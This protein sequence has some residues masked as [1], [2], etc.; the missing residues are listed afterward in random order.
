MN[1]GN[2]AL[3]PIVSC[4]LKNG[5]R[6]RPIYVL[7]DSGCSSAAILSV[8]AKSVEVVPVSHR[9]KLATFDSDQTVVRDF[10][11]FEVMSLDRTVC[12]S[13][14]EALVGDSLTVS[15]DRPPTNEE[16]TPFDY[17]RG[18]VF[19]ELA[20]TTIGIIL[21]APYAHLWMDGETR[22]HSLKYPLA[23]RTKLGW[24]LI[25]PTLDAK[26]GGKDVSVAAC[27]PEMLNLHLEVK[28]M[29]RHEYIMPGPFVHPE[30]VFPSRQD[31][32][33]Q[34]QMEKSIKFDL[35]SGRYSVALPWRNGRKEAA[36]R[37][38]LANSYATARRRLL[39]EKPK[40]ERDEFRRDGVFA[41]LE[42][43]IN[44]GHVRRVVE[45]DLT[46]KP[47]WYS[48]VVIVE[49]PSKPVE[50]RFRMCQDC[51][52]VSQS[53]E[54]GIWLNAELSTGPDV[55]TRLTSILFKF[56][57]HPY[58]LMADVSDFFH[59]I[60][61]NDEDVAALRFLFFKDKSMREIE[62]FELLVHLFGGGSSPAVA[63][64]T[65]QYHAGRIRAKYGEFIYWEIMMKFYVDDYL[66]SVESVQKA[67]DT[68]QQMTAAL[69]E[70][71]F[72]LCKWASNDDR[73]LA[74][75]VV[76]SSQVPLELG[77]VASEGP[78]SAPTVAQ[79][80]VDPEI[81]PLHSPLSPAPETE[82]GEDIV[83]LEND[84]P[85]LSPQ[86]KARQ[87][88]E[89]FNEEMKGFVRPDLDASTKV[90]GVGYDKKKDLLFVR[91]PAQAEKEVFTMTDVL[92]IVSAYFDPLGISAPYVLEGKLIFQE[93]V[94][95]KLTWKEP[96]PQD[97]K[98]RFMK[99][100]ATRDGLRQVSV[101]RWTS[102]WELGESLVDLC[103]YADASNEGYGASAY[104]RRY[105]PGEETVRTWLIFGKGHVV[106]T[107]MH[108]DKFEGQID[109]NGSIPRVELT[110]AR[111]AAEICSMV[112]RE[113]GETFNN[114]YLFADSMSVILWLRD[115][116]R[117]HKTF[118]F[119]R[120]RRIWNLTEVPWWRYCPTDSNP[121][122]IL[123]HPLS[124][125][126]RDAEK[127]RLYLEGPEWLRLPTSQWPTEPDIPADKLVDIAV[128]NALV[129]FDTTT[130]F[131]PRQSPP[132][133]AP[134]SVS[135]GV[136]SAPAL[137]VTP[138]DSPSNSSSASS[139]AS[140]SSS[141]HASSLPGRS[142][143]LAPVDHRTIVPPVRDL[144]LELTEKRSK[145]A[146][147]VN[148]IA[149]LTQYLQQ[150]KN[151]V[152]RRPV[153]PIVRTFALPSEFTVAEKTLLAA[154]QRKYFTAE[155]QLLL[156]NAVF[157][158]NA[159]G[160]EF[161]NRKSR[162]TNL[163]P[164]LDG[165]LMRSGSRIEHADVAYD[166]RFPIVL[167]AKS[168][169]VYSLVR[170]IHE[171]MGHAQQ[172]HLLNLLRRRFCIL[173][174]RA[175]V[176][177]IIRY[178][179]KCQRFDKSPTCQ[180]MAVLPEF[181]VKVVWP[182]RF[183][184]LDVLGP[185]AVTH[186]GRG[187]NKRWILLLTCPSTR[188]IALYPLVSM[189]TQAFLNALTKFQSAY[190]GLQQ[191]V[192]DNGSNFAG[193][194]NLCRELVEEFNTEVQMGELTLRNIEFRF[195]PP[196][197]PHTGG[198]FE[199]LVRSVKRV[200]NFVLTDEK[201]DF[202]AF[203]TSLAKCAALVNSRPLGPVSNDI[204]SIQCLSP[205]HFLT[206]YMYCPDYSL[207]P[208]VTLCSANLPG[209]WF[210]VR[211]LYDRFKEG[212]VD[213]Y[214]ITLLKRSKWHKTQQDLYIG[215]LV[216]IAGPDKPRTHWQ[217]GRVDKHLPSH[218]NVLRR[219]IVKLP[220]GRTFE[221]HHNALVPLELE[222]EPHTATPAVANA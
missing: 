220:D 33:A 15:G 200:L 55:L 208:P 199:R 164:F 63:N 113:G 174:E 61:V 203:D 78:G 168:T 99:W 60:W 151:F 109:H 47:V 65:L 134:V 41:Q 136:T 58:T 160:H 144:I 85:S 25:G 169:E 45:R 143:S 79:A 87:E 197:A 187:M 131:P 19:D 182:F 26:E 180:K 215:Q 42:K 153:C 48:P 201:V 93:C 155:M 162:L 98:E 130:L 221:R 9:C 183:T 103:V 77:P 96:L 95:R 122:D 43:L 35:P 154:I 14:P 18:V 135:N 133:T 80:T 5:V 165:L 108:V 210:A 4:I 34:E 138:L 10:A 120:L 46:D 205:Q 140:L 177:H 146:A 13:V 186:A 106:P 189:S 53:S 213:E 62:S 59:R 16:I 23:K 175:T 12:V 176:A 114:V 89:L 202:D 104:L 118:E 185:Y 217:I 11:S 139:S 67:R 68:K 57:R 73:V 214:L 40:L 107:R 171:T 190:P 145:W 161:G 112:Q 97:L 6:E 32:F 159:K 149:R 119:F 193:A 209:T 198:V 158:P 181:R 84:M 195:N 21:G 191:I 117:K 38:A 150:F 219:Y 76:S 172:T 196:S 125:R 127:W 74:D 137:E 36:R 82:E 27:D 156:S 102:T 194:A 94:N 179:L 115:V 222:G 3:R 17:L 37:F 31:E 204:N 2:R 157:S 92:S 100:L 126:A 166:T 184:A 90:L 121:S 88:E 207:D 142:V 20:D 86:Q 212:W 71:G 163:N 206:P 54:G 167:P 170:H 44:Q 39:R 51:G 70:G 178:C 91:I 7:F 72:S 192:C 216:L 141:L 22:F 129:D 124:C 111:L 24:V 123:T 105:L 101:P 132:R 110:A 75:D 147:K 49:Q 69:A 148:K 83:M 116:D 211:R 81:E 173:D 56:R 8:A 30:K 64:F 28:R 188:A 66:T 152:R 50:K 218:D 52:S 1:G 29:F 128:F